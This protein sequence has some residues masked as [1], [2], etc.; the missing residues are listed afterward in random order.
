M[1]FNVLIIIFSF[2]N[3]EEADVVMSF[4][5]AMLR[6]GTKEE[7][8][9]II[10]PYAAQAKYIRKEI[11]LRSR[12][13]MKISTVDSFQGNQL[14]GCSCAIFYFIKQQQTKDI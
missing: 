14:L 6:D 8:I 7:E 3:K 9:G 4:V 11:K 2:V 12:S 1:I 5:N 10:S 13:P